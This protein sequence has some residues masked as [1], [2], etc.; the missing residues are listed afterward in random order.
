MVVDNPLSD[1]Q[2]ERLDE[3]LEG[4]VRGSFEDMTV[5][6]YDGD[7]DYEVAFREVTTEPRMR[8]V[9]LGLVWHD[10]ESDWEIASSNAS[11]WLS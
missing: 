9:V 1:E 11:G 10:D 6:T 7:F 4:F 2:Q 3:L 5:S 8:D